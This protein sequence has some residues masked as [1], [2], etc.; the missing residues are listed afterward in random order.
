MI[1]KPV[2][3]YVK[4]HR[5]TGLKYFGKTVSKNPYSY[6]GSGKYW[7]NH[8]AVH[9]YDVD[10]EIIG[11]YTD[12]EQ[13]LKDALEFS[14]KNEIVSSNIWANLKE[15]TLDG[16]WDHVNSK[17]DEER[18][19]WN[20][21]GTQTHP[22]ARWDAQ[23]KMNI[24]MANSEFQKEMGTRG[25]N[26]CKESKIGWFS[27][28]GKAKCLIAVK[29]EAA[30]LKHSMTARLNR[31]YDGEKNS[32]FGSK[33][34]YNDSYG[35]SYRIN[36]KLIDSYLESGWKFGMHSKKYANNGKLDKSRKMK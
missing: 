24:C 34:M 29:S 15:E 12:L 5:V 18:K 31:S 22:T 25:G 3:L 21:K 4:T 1:A 17:H 2:Y 16:G 13:C 20:R 32:Q 26:K 9:G 33:W 30:R 19:A 8:L 10:T 23:K 35:L 36:C 11:C 28:E 6:K 27:D 7:R 14:K